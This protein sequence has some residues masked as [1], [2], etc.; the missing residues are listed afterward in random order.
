MFSVSSSEP[1]E[2]ARDLRRSSGLPCVSRGFTLVELLVV[3]AII[4]ILA[5]M[6][7][8]MFYGAK[9]RAREVKAKVVVKALETAFKAYLDTYKVWPSAITE[10]TVYDVADSDGIALYSMLSGSLAGAALNPQGIT[11]MDFEYFTNAAM[12]STT[13]W[14]PWSNPSDASM[15]R[16]YHVMFDRNYDNQVKVDGKD[17]YRCVV[18]WS[19]GKNRTDDSG[20]GDDVASWK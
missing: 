18:V 6:M 15:H 8:P 2:R 17:V 19:L 7:M 11:F 4:A 5:G 3:I 10:G 9:E 13:A 16:A 1:G 12:D 20:G 14:D